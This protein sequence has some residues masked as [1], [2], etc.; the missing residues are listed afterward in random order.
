MNMASQSS[1]NNG[2]NRFKTSYFVEKIAYFLSAPA[3][4]IQA[5]ISHRSRLSIRKIIHYSLP[6]LISFRLIYYI[7]DFHICLLLRILHFQKNL[8]NQNRKREINL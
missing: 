8:R 2:M 5:K 6:V 7:S 4:N 1:V 3:V